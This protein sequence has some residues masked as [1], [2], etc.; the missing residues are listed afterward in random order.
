MRL[1]NLPH[2]LKIMACFA[3]CTALLSGTLTLFGCSTPKIAAVIDQ[4]E[5]TTGEYLAYLFN[6]YQ[7]TFYNYNLSA[8]AQNNLDPWEQKLP[9]GEGDDEKELSVEEYIIQVTKDTMIRQKAL[10][11]KLEEYK[12]SISKEDLEKYDSHIKSVSED[13]MI[14]MGFNKDSY[15]KMYKA[16]NFNEA[17]LFYGLYDKGGKRAMSEKE[18]RD[19][20]DKNIMCYKIIELALTDEQGSDLDKDGVAKVKE[21]LQGYLDLYKQNKDFD[22]VIE[23]FNADREQE[24]NPTTTTTTAET[25]SG[26]AVTT[27][28]ATTTTTAPTT[29]T[30]A[31]TTTT[32]AATTT[33]TSKSGDDKEPEEPEEPED[34]NLRT[35]DANIDEENIVK[36]VQSVKVGEAKIVEYKQNGTTN[37]AALILRIDPEQTQYKFE[38]SRERV[39]YGAKYEDF[40]KEIKEYIKTLDVK[41][42]KTVV[43]KCTPKKLEKDA[44]GA[45]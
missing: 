34:S 13:A 42:N 28:A 18:I 19:Y 2:N 33:T 5:Y 8:Y 29:T 40:D 9:Y 43:K 24:S 3:A 6:T 38:K 21:K 37:T 44:T 16:V 11:D 10:S 27:T 12:I 45:A 36:A 25:T 1:R 15:G 30:T 41:F 17:T 26:T 32:T 4:K 31:P 35:L 22:K 20:Y 7:M 14:K 23:K 39:I